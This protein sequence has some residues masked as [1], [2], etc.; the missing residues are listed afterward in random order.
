MVEKVVDC[1]GKSFTIKD[2]KGA[3]DPFTKFF[4][5]HPND[6]SNIARM[7]VDR[8]SKKDLSIVAFDRN[9]D[10]IVGCIINE[11]WKQKEPEDYKHLDHVWDPVVSIFSELH[12]Q[13]KKQHPNRI[14][15]GEILHPLYFTCVVPENRGKGI[16]FEMWNQ[17][18][19]I[20]RN[21]NFQYMVCE[22]SSKSS[23]KLCDQIGFT[24]RSIVSYNSWKYKGQ[25]IFSELPVIDPNFEKLTMWEKK[26]PSNLY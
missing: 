5:L 10:E 16:A 22:T 20:A 11:D 1:I 12:T 8:A 19:E 13:Y 25:N 15:H 26:I 3:I 24:P 17:S 9:S 14:H 6:W 21:Y 4:K 23:E 18:V 7:F 2:T